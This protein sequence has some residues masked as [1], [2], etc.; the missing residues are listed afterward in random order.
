VVFHWAAV[1]LDVWLA[2]VQRLEAWVRGPAPFRR[3]WRALPGDLLGL[4]VMRGCGIAGPTREVRAGDV[5]AVLVEDPRVGRWFDRNLVPVTAQTLGRYVLSRGPV[6]P[7][8]LAHECEHIRQWQ[9]FGPFFLALYGGSSA[10]ALA[11]GRKPYW[12]N[13]FEAAARSRAERDLAGVR[14]GGRS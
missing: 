4:L 5:S 6:P 7:H 10:V 8:I 3:L 12:D 9:R 13:H 14:D 1:I 11:R 2:L